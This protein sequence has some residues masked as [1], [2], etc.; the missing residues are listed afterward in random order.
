MISVGVV[1][2][3]YNRAATIGAAIESVLR[4]TRP[5]DRIVVV[6]DGSTD[7]T[8][9]SV[10]RFGDGVEIIR[11]E[12]AGAAAARQRGAEA[13]D[14]DWLAFLDSDD[15]YLPTHLERHVEAAARLP[16]D[17][18][19]IFG[20]GYVEGRGENRQRLIRGQV[21]WGDQERLFDQALDAWYPVLRCYLQ[22]SLLRRQAFQS[23][24]G[25]LPGLRSED[26]LLAAR[27]ET[28]GRFAYLAEPLWVYDDSGEE[29]RLSEGY[30]HDPHYHRARALAFQ[31]VWQSERLRPYRAVY[32][33]GYVS[34]LRAYAAS[35]LRAGQ[36]GSAFR[37]AW[38]AAVA[39]RDAKALL[40]ALLSIAG[41]S[42]GRVWDRLHRA[43]VS[44]TDG[45]GTPDAGAS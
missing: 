21:P 35:E 32:R 31:T 43:R 38:R 34:C 1:I 6:D 13:L 23:C 2:P 25:F 40:L 20:D 22:A 4:Q 17:V 29:G 24:G 30:L 44:A 18:V 37:H 8:V 19:W 39:G 36:S 15:A 10:G 7:E 16:D 14:T 27:M 33:P 42:G 28:Q 3:A 12:N 5:A 41:R 26:L 11:Q 45:K 9:A